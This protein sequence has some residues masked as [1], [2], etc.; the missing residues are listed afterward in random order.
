[1]VRTKDIITHGLIIEKCPFCG[2]KARIHEDYDEYQSLIGYWV[3][4]VNPLCEARQRTFL[5]TEK[6]MAIETWNKRYDNGTD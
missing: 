4:C 5:K 6:R 2:K 1:M 3:E